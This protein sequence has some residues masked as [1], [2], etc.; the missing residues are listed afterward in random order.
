[1]VAGAT[2][3]VTVVAGRVILIAGQEWTTRV[4]SGWLAAVKVIEP[5][6]NNYTWNPGF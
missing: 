1:V 2:P 6:S 5:G 4:D 3:I